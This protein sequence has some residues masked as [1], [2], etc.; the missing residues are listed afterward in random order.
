MRETIIL[1]DLNGTQ[2]L[3]TLAYH[4]KNTIGVRVFNAFQL[5]EEA[6]LRNGILAKDVLKRN[7]E[8][9]VI[10]SFIRDIP[11][12]SSA[13][14]SDARQ[15]S[16]AFR[17]LRNLV[18]DE[19]EKTIREKL[20][21]DDFREKN[22]AVLT[23]YELYRKKLN[24]QPDQIDVIRKAIEECKPLDCDFVCFEEYPL[25]PL[26]EKLLEVL[27]DHTYRK[28]S[29]IEYAGKKQ[30]AYHNITYTKAYGNTSEVE[31]VVS[32]IYG[33]GYP[34]D[35]C[36]VAAA[37]QEK[38]G[39]LFQEY[40]KRLDIPMSFGFGTA[41]SNTDPARLLKLYAFWDDKGYH[42]IDAL[43]DM[44][45]S[46]YFNIDRLYEKIPEE[47][48]EYYLKE[49]LRQAGRL[50]LDSDVELNN[51]K[52]QEFKD[53][54]Y[55]TQRWYRKAYLDTIAQELGKGCSYFIREY[56]RIRE[57]S[58][59][60][61]AVNV[62]CSSIDTY[63]NYVPDGSY[64][65]ILDEL[66]NKRISRGISR[67]GALHVTDIVSASDS[68]RNHVFV[69]G[70][71]A[72]NYPGSPKENHLLLDEDLL[73]FGDDVPTS[74][75]IIERKKQSLY[76]LIGLCSSLDMDIHLSYSSYDMSELKDENPSSLLFEIYKKQY[77]EESTSEDFDSALIEA[78]YFDAHL[79]D[80]A[81]IGLAFNR[82][83]RIL[84]IPQGDIRD[85]PFTGE[86]K[87]SPT[88]LEDFFVCPKMFYLRRIL[89]IE[90]PDPDDPFV[91]I[92]A[93][94][95]GTLAH[96]MMEYLANRKITKEEFLSYCNTSFSNFLKYRV[97]L[98]QSDAAK[99]RDEFISMMSRSYE[100]D[101]HNEVMA[102]EEK[103]TVP[104]PSGI[105][106]Y[107][108]PDSVEKDRDGRY[109]IADFKTKRN[110]DHVED[111]ILT[112]LQVVLYAYM[113]AHKDKDPLPISYCEYR[114]LRYGKTIRCHYNAGIEAQ[115][116][117]M[118]NVVSKAMDEGFYPCAED[119]DACRYCKFLKICG[120]EKEKKETE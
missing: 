68:L 50:K 41:L 58:E 94:D 86:R 96:S 88:N 67:E 26:E 95:L 39:P 79:S 3:R 46:P 48:N 7:E 12:F 8:A 16:E 82:G 59:D 32:C 56:A 21:S 45:F 112:C 62:I 49:N 97:P 31:N 11:Y 6:L 24:G 80:S 2:L 52:L 120:K 103:V 71:S 119:K 69:V 113:I 72:E 9:Y 116:E 78:G 83:G 53:T 102:A 14:F 57:N 66:L 36:T 38:F 110:F 114:Y 100:S 27:S 13:S 65:D 89:K 93:R 10:D 101:P 51:K 15:L 76:D 118:L 84:G 55:A 47:R 35:S 23:A 108:Y 109:L 61:T 40:S 28:V 54:V 73:R 106:L 25:T 1:T 107:G 19:E 115:L 42:G 92:D 111:D 81:E 77:G 90:E 33:N 43:I 29:L 4:G 34:L 63:L 64:K 104:H 98:H 37:D 85:V 17:T 30:E 91:V 74:E 105:L 5:A 99:A 70:L 20:V 75:Q 44:V 87:F 60:E 18:I 22:E 117:R